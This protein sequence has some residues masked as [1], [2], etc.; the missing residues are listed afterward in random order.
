MRSDTNSPRQLFNPR[1]ATLPPSGYIPNSARILN[2]CRPPVATKPNTAEG[3]TPIA[4]D[5]IN[6]FQYATP[7]KWTPEGEPIC[8]ACGQAGHYRRECTGKNIPNDQPVQADEPQDVIMQEVASIDNSRLTCKVK[9]GFY[10]VRALIDTGAAISIINTYT[11]KQIGPCFKG[12]YHA[13]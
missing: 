5:Q 13:E 7:L 4:G 6:R 3:A 1:F 11:L 8:A 9:F 2:Y 10:E 12:K